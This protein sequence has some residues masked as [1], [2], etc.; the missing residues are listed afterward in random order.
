MKILLHIAPTYIVLSNNFTIKVFAETN[1]TEM[2][3]IKYLA[4][5]KKRRKE[6]RGIVIGS[7]ILSF[8]AR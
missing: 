5:R 4:K 6:V 8:R 1:P 2:D 7:E 3:H